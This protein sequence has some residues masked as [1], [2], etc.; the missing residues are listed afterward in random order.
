[1][2]K[3]YGKGRNVIR[4][5]AQSQSLL[6]AAADRFSARIQG[7]C[8]APSKNAKRKRW[9]DRHFPAMNFPNGE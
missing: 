9:L 6:V 4:S 1:M 7:E 3:L 5:S 8:G 2:G